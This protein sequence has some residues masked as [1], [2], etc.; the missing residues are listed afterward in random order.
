MDGDGSLLLEFEAFL[1]YIFGKKKMEEMIGN[2]GCATLQRLGKPP[3]A[4]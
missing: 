2:Y 3:D 1:W 4:L